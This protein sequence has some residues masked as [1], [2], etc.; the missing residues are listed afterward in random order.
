MLILGLDPSFR[1]W[2]ISK[3]TYDTDSKKLSVFHGEVLTSNHDLYSKQNQKDLYSAC[4]LSQKLAEHWN[5]DIDLVCIELPHGS[6]SAR[7]MVSYGVVLGVLSQ[8]INKGIPTICTSALQ[9]KDVVGNRKATKK[10]VIQWV[11]DN[12]TEFT[13]PKS[14]NKAEH[15][16]D[17]IV[18]IHAVL[19]SKQFKEYLNENSIKY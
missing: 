19:A 3:A 8:F 2:G 11:K 17:S 12:H 6:Q 4:L 14:L 13:L 16:A 7:A 9:V 1:N 18:A 5:D 15:I 10:E